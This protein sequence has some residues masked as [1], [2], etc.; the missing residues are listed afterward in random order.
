M[1]RAGTAAYRK[2]GT[3]NGEFTLAEEAPLGTYRIEATTEE[4]GSTGNF[5]VAEYKKP[6]YKVNVATPQRFAASGTKTKFTID[7]RYFFGAPVVGAEVKYYIYRNR[8]YL[9][10]S[11]ESEEEHEDEQDAEQ[12]SRYGNYYSDFVD[13]GDG[14]LDSSGHYEIEFEVPASQANEVTDYQ[15]RLEAQITDSSRRTIDGSATVIA[16]RGSIIA[17]AVPDRYVFKQGQ[18]A[19]IKIK[20]TDY[21]GHP[22]PSKLTLKF[23]SPQMTVVTN[24]GAPQYYVTDNDLS[25]GRN[26]HGSAGRGILR[27]RGNNTGKHLDQNGGPGKGQTVRFA[28]RLPLGCQPGL[29]MERFAL[30]QREHRYDQTGRGQEVVPRRRDRSRVGNSSAGEREPSHH[31]RARQRPL[32]V[33][34]E[35]YGQDHGARRPGREGLCA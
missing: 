34:S 11:G 20:T 33:E 2:I 27:L 15:Y 25:I 26:Q 5:D 12:Y 1:L 6:E 17:S 9:P 28:W 21:E 8:Y 30:L 14:K 13:Q 7:A 31:Q 10:F 23:V 3:F 19:R 35:G 18:T 22:V 24:N 32:C 16:T 29:P 4:G